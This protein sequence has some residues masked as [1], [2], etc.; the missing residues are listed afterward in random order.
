MHLCQILC[1]RC[2]AMSLNSRPTKK[3]PGGAGL[4]IEIVRLIFHG[5]KHSG[6]VLRRLGQNF[7]L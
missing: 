6:K 2:A 4:L 5:D 7:A 3:G 1:D